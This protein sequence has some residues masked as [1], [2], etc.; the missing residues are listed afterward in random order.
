VSS[1]RAEQREGDERSGGDD[2]VF[3]HSTDKVPRRPPFVER[4]RPGVMG[5]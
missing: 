5:A 4:A 3:Y 2:S 1:A